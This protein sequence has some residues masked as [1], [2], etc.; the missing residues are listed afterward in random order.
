MIVLIVYI[1]Y[2][3]KENNVRVGDSLHELCDDQRHQIEQQHLSGEVQRIQYVLQSGRTEKQQTVRAQPDVLFQLWTQTS[4][5]DNLYEPWGKRDLPFGGG[6]DPWPYQE[7]Q[8][9]YLWEESGVQY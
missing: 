9:C 1:D 2:K 6:Q 5:S 3:I 8:W 7:D 4:E